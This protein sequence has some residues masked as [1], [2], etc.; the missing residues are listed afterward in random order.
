MELL[1]GDCEKKCERGKWSGIDMGL[2]YAELCQSQECINSEI[3]E[4]DNSEGL[5]DYKTNSF[6]IIFYV[7]TSYTIILAADC[8]MLFH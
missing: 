1:S 2:R 3:V 7:H 5:P 4:K 6:F 8:F